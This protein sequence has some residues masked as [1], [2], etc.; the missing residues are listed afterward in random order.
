M[1]LEEFT[2]GSIKDLGGGKAALAFAQ[3]VR[4]AALDCKDRPGDGAARKVTLE[5]VLSPILQPD[6]DCDEVSAQLKVSSTVPK[7]QTKPYSFG[8]RANGMLTFNPDSLDNVDQATMLKD[9]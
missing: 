4:R 5:L 6:G 1:G 8:L 7:Q 3:H 9:D 2:L